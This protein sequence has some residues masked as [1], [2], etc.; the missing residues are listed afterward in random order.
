MT[1]TLALKAGMV[2]SVG[3]LPHHDADEAAEFVLRRHPLVPSAPQLP[4]RSPLEGMIAQAARGIPGVS[5]APDGS[6]TVDTAVL[7]PEAPTEP[8]LDGAGHA[9][10][11]AFLSLV[12]GRT[13]PIKI[14][15]TGPITL[16]LALVAAG[17]EP[18]V[19]FP[20]A[21]Q[22]V[23]TRGAA[24]VA[25]CR[26]RLP[27]A[28][29]LAFLDEPGL[30][31]VAAGGLPLDLDA[32]TDLLSSALAA[33]ELDATT[34]VHCCAPTDWR[35]VSAAGPTVLSLPATVDATLA[36]AGSLGHHLER[37]GWVAWGAV[38]THEP[39]GTDA[40]RLWR[41]LTAIW[42]ELVKAGC[43]PVQLRAQAIVTPA[44]GLAGHGISQASRSLY[45]AV[46]L[47]KRVSDQAVA[48]R[49]SMGA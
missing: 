12:A 22:A 36:S 25:L 1:T 48:A 40:D 20:V 29:L 16:G 8:C 31:A 17:A 5:V 45:L 3:S 39:L 21:L 47:A 41:R 19:A 30:G 32:A 46:E 6:L 7:D 49:L 18:K 9:G 26:R 42:C 44:C 28:P 11:L 35:L 13:D 10:L 2:T 24:L 14:Q 23:R 43:D 4:H 34:G 33:L 15:L 38:P 27:Q 37:G